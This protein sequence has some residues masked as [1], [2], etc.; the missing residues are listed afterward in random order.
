M[1]NVVRS[2][3]A[4]IL[5]SIIVLGGTLYGQTDTIRF[6]FLT[7]I[8]FGKTAY[9]GTGEP[10]YPATWLRKAL[11]GIERHKAE[12]ILVGGDLIES[13]NALDQYAMFDSSMMTSLPWYPMPGNHD[14]GATPASATMDKINTW[15]QRKYGRGPNNREYYGFVKKSVGAFFVL[16]TQAYISTDPTVVAR[17]DSQLT[18]MDAFFTANAS[19]P[20]KFVCSHV[21]LFTQLQGEDSAY[22]NIGKTYRNRIITVMNKHNAKYY[23]AGHRHENAVVTD[24]GITVY[25]NT[26]LS[27]QLGSGNERGYYIYTVTANSVRRD[28]YPLAQDP[29]VVRWKW[30]A[31]G[32]TRTNDAAHRSV[33]QAMKNN[34]PDYRFIINVGDDVEDGANV[35]LWNA[36]KAACDQILGGTGQTSVPPKYMTAAG[37]HEM[38]EAGGLANWR[39]YMSGQVNQFGHDGKYFTFDYENARFVVLYSEVETDPAQKQFLL[40][41]IQTNTKKWLF[42]IWHKPVFDF[43][44]KVYEAGIH[45][46]WAMPLYQN[47]CDIYFNGH[48]HQYVRSKKLNLNGQQNPPLDATNGTVQI[49]TGNGGA[50]LA[51]ADENHDGNGYLVAYSFDQNQ[52]AYYGYTELV[53]DGDTLFM[54]HLRASDGQLM[55]QEVYHPNFKPLVGV[56]YHLDIRTVGTG[57]VT[58]TPSDTVFNPGTPVRILAVPALGWKFDG[59]SGDRTGTANPDTVV[60]DGEKTVTATFSQIPAGQYEVRTA[61]LGEG[62]VVAE[63]PGPYYSLNTVVTLKARAAAGSIFDGWSRD[64]T[65]TDTVTTVT[66]DGNKSVGAT[67]R[68]L[69]TFRINARTG[70]H[71]SVTMSPAGG[72]YAEGTQ[73]TLQAT[74]ETGWELYEWLGDVNGKTGQ[75]SVTVNGN[76]D[77]RTVF[78]KTGGSVQEVGATHDSYVQGFLKSSTNFNT[79]SCLQV[80]EGNSDMYR[81]RAYVQ[82]DLRGVTGNVLGAVM[83]L[84]VK[85]TGLPDGKGVGAG[86]YAVG[87]DSWLETTLKWTGA[88]AAG[89]LFDTAAVCEVGNVYGWDLASCVAGEMSGDRVVSVMVKDYRAMDKRINFERREDG[90]GPVLALITDGTTGVEKAD[91]IPTEFVLHQNYPNPFNPETVISYQIP[92]ASRIVVKIFDMLAREVTTLVDQEKGPGWYN[93]RW[94]ASSYPSGVYLCRMT[95]GAFSSGIKLLYLK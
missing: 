70:Q 88:P 64:A 15:I 74:A 9:E 21:P 76:K 56:R 43:G 59:W 52:A 10:L 80:R 16:N 92:T 48:A 6:G 23:L 69:E 86:V 55:D 8:H 22:F 81:S 62:L 17:A 41:A 26:A 53:V 28:F 94:D 3:R 12:F 34:T 51:A 36:W 1:K 72:V 37:N 84:K 35:T 67:F 61:V 60:M 2:I 83:K 32:D 24:G 87:T 58:T 38:L 77:I 50:P 65:G 90:N 29:D 63:P 82:F 44:V 71:G 4:L 40:D 5:L 25:A 47:G 68:K 30:I 75:Q 33:L 93:V 42:A 13:S 27:F 46:N 31:Y 91:G 79:D 14:I 39:I 85:S 89:T 18:E 95:A 54:R 45:Q 7:D 49:I 73:V 78:R 20:N 19:M 57:I 66:V 11:A